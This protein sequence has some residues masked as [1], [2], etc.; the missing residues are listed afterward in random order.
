MRST[1]N[2]RGSSKGD[3]SLRFPSA[4]PSPSPASR[5]RPSFSRSVPDPFGYS[6]PRRQDESKDHFESSDNFPYQQDTRPP[7]SAPAGG[8]GT[9]AKNASA[10]LNRFEERPSSSRSSGSR[11]EHLS[12]GEA[13]TGGPSSA[14]HFSSSPSSSSS[15]S[16]TGKHTAT[17]GSSPSPSSSQ[18]THSFSTGAAYAASS[19]SSLMTGSSSSG[20]A[21]GDHNGASSESDDDQRRTFPPRRKKMG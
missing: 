3:E 17:F 2:Y 4:S 11:H 1:P 16:A 12:P 14:S 21:R 20:S 6:T 15:R 8:D 5:G 18:G 13:A 19:A 7:S 9:F 10:G